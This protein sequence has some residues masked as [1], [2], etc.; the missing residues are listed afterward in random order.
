MYDVR[1]SLT[2][3]SAEADDLEA[4]LTAAATIVRDAFDARPVQGRAAKAR[5]SLLVTRDGRYDPQATMLA[6]AGRRRPLSDEWTE[7]TS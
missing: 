5:G 4:A 6:R 2:G 3:D 1:C 7:A